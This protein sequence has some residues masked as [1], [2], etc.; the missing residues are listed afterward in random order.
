MRDSRAIIDP[1]AKLHASVSVGPFSM[2]DANVEI[3]EGTVIGPHVIIRGPTRI[4][5]HNHIFQFSSIGEMPQDKKFGNEETRL[6]IGDYN[7]IREFCTLNRG[8]AQDQGVT[9][10]GH[11]NLLMAYVHIAH[12]CVLEDHIVMANSASLAGHVHIESF[13]GLGGMSGVHQFCR[14]GA[15]SFAAGGSMIAKDVLPYIKV[16]GYYAKPFG[17]NAIGLE[18]H[19][20]SKEAIECLKEAYK[21]IYRQNL[22]VADALGELQKLEA[23]CPEVTRMRVALENSERGIAR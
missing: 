17:L 18:R 9:K 15:Y 21:I 2:I 8:T 6:E 4:G 19:Q 20:F 10:I 11:H 16:S 22:V 14:I 12:D 5:K 7:V 23:T 1:A 3:G 13:V